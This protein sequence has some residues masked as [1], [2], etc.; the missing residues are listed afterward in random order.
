MEQSQP[1][2]DADG[3]SERRYVSTAQV[4]QALGVSV[5][6]VK[7]WVDDRV[8]PAHRTPGGHRKLLMADVLRLVRAG[9]LPQTDLTKLLPKA[10]QESLD[11]TDAL[12]QLNAAIDAGDTELIRTVLIGAYQSGIAMDILADKVVSPAM[13]KVGHE[14]EIGRLPVLMEHRVSQALMA[15]M[16]E[17]RA[18]LRV[19]AEVEQPVAVGGAPEHDHSALPSLMAKLTLLDAGWEAVN[20]GPHTPTFALRGAIDDLKP[21]LV[22]VSVTH[23]QYPDQF[24]A[25]FNALSE[26]AEQ[27]NVAIALGGRGLTQGIRER[28]RYTTFGDGFGQLLAFAKTLH[29]RRPRPKRGRPPV[30]QTEAIAPRRSSPR[31]AATT[32]RSAC[33]LPLWSPGRTACCGFRSA[34]SRPAGGRRPFVAP[35]P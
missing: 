34:S 1:P 12:R 35:P 27:K 9:N 14:W 21:Q 32:A 7:R 25:D 16:Y 19:N 17:L 20:L 13:Q 23:L 26:Y 3:L 2:L 29:H 24:V 8:L 31:S 30:H 28:L 22:W 18:H 5:T 15:A 4:A 10:A 6:T 11:P 33:P